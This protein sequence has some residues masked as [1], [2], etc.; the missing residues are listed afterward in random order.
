V[1]DETERAAVLAEIKDGKAYLFAGD[2]VNV[3]FAQGV[4]LT[5]L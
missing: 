1:A 5:K 4:S 2:V 3:D